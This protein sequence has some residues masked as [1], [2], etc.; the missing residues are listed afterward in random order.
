[1][2]QVPLEVEIADTDEL[3]SQ[4]LMY[5]Q[6]MA[7][8]KGMLF[9]FSKEKTL[10][11]WMKNTFIPLSIGFFDKDRKLIEVQKMRPMRP[12]R[13]MK[14]MRSMNS[15]IKKNIPLYQSRKP[16]QYAIEVNQGWFRKHKIAI[17]TKWK[18]AKKAKP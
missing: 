18:W 5:R 16:A 6:K 13:P 2:G 9:I 11:F 12:M 15:I 8:D 14:S 3:R 10:S 1:M 17:G 4:G 7:D